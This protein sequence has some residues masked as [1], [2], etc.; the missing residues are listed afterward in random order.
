VLLLVA[1]AAGGFAWQQRQQAQREAHMARAHEW[2]AEA[3]NQLTIDPERSVWLALYALEESEAAGVGP[4]PEA[5]EALH[6]AVQAVRILFTLPHDEPVLRVRFRADGTRLVTVDEQAVVRVWDVT[7]PRPVPKPVSVFALPRQEAGTP[8]STYGPLDISPDGARVAL[9]DGNAVTIWDVASGQL[10]HTLVRKS[11]TAVRSLVFSPDG[12]RLA[13]NAVATTIWDTLTGQELE[14][15]NWGSGFRVTSMALSPDSKQLAIATDGGAHARIVDV[16]TGSR[17]ANLY[18]DP[19]GLLGV[20]YSPDGENLV[21]AGFRAMRVWDMASGEQVMANESVG[22]AALAFSP[23]G[24][25]LATGEEVQE[26]GTPRQ[27]YQLLGHT[28]TLTS[29]SYSPDGTRLASASLD[30]TVRVWDTAPTREWLTLSRPDLA[31]ESSTYDIEFGP[32]SGLEGSM[33]AAVTWDYANNTGWLARWDVA[34]GQP[35][36]MWSQNGLPLDL[37]FSPDGGRLATAEFAQVSV[38]DAVTG[39][40]T[41]I[42][43]STIEQLTGVTFYPDG[44]RVAFIDCHGLIRVWEMAARKLAVAIETIDPSGPCTNWWTR[45]SVSPD[46][47]LLAV[48]GPDQVLRLFDA[49]TGQLLHELDGHDDRLYGLAFSADGTLLAVGSED[50]TI[51]I[52]EAATAALRLRLSGH[53]QGVHSLAFSPDGRLL[54]STAWDGETKLW[55]LDR[56]QEKLTLFRE[57][58]EAAGLAFSPDGEFLATAGANGRVRV[59]LP[60]LEDLVALA[61]TRIT[62]T[63]TP[64]E[65]QRYLRLEACP[66][67]AASP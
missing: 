28:N 17:V 6:R 30:R 33:L 67:L 21:T 32:A 2:A 46:G 45:L 66:T 25:Q 10:Q 4:L 37:S 57:L 12:S 51:T 24:R 9:G 65:C 54:A 48:A 50:T 27:L 22:S 40:K 56:Q 44:T 53:S 55:D 20:M 29:L 58:N 23:D 47:R 31:A 8:I 61:H 59:F 15:G 19:A 60:Y 42:A 3:V 13:V 41:T 11:G 26:A 64:E 39:S 14:S 63:L 35:L 43:S 49:Y 62:R 18:A 38:W 7:A 34:T 5:E 16:E 52:W 36:P 1:A